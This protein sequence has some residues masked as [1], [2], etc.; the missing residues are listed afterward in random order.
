MPN[1]KRL[2]SLSRRTPKS[3]SLSALVSLMPDKSVCVT[4]T[5]GG[6]ETRFLISADGIN[7]RMERQAILGTHESEPILKCVGFLGP[8]STIYSI[9]SF[10]PILWL[11]RSLHTR[12][13][14]LH[15]GLRIMVMYYFTHDKTSM[16]IE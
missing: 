15:P 2:P 6:K 1:T 12:H 5:H 14:Y 11:L 13:M 7:V 9:E 10:L 4:V 8:K 3:C 16:K